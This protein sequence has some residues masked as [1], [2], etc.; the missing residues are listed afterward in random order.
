MTAPSIPRI[1]ARKPKVRSGCVTCKAR[2]VKC[3]EERPVCR[4]CQKSWLP[5]KYNPPETN[6]EKH[7]NCSHEHPVTSFQAD[8]SDKCDSRLLSRVR[9][10][11]FEEFDTLYLD[12]FRSAIVQNL[13]LNG[14][15][16]FWSR[17][18][19]RE[20]FRDECVRDCVLGIGALRRAM[21]DET[22]H[23]SSLEPSALWIVPKVATASLSTRYQRDAIRYYTESIS[24]FRSR[25]SR[26]GSSTPPRTILILSILFVM[27][28]AIQGNSESV[29]RIIHTTMLTLEDCA[30]GL[31]AEDQGSN[32]LDD[33]GV[34][35]ADYFLT[36][37][38]G[39]NSLLSP[40]YPSLL[41]GPVFQR[42]W[43]L[44]AKIPSWSDDLQQVE[45]AFE[46]YTT[47]S[48][49]WFLRICQANIFGHPT[50]PVK[51]QDEQ[52][53]IHLQAND[54]CEFISTK[55]GQETDPLRHRTWKM[56]LVEAKMFRIYSTYSR[57]AEERELLWDLQVDDC[58]EV[59][60]IIESILDELTSLTA[61][62]PLFED[63]LLPTLRCVAWKCRDYEIR[64]KALGLCKRLAGPWFENRA[65]L[66][67]LRIMI[68]LE[69]RDRDESGFIPLRSR[70]R[71][72]I[73]SF[74]DDRTEL[75]I[76]LMRL[77]TGA[78]KE[79]TI[80]QDGNIDDLV[81]K[82]AASSAKS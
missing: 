36:R 55:L 43:S 30:P 69:E 60:S 2:R 31:G 72:N 13:C 76:G 1:R 82:L 20:I 3:G 53:I 63:K 17:T 9:R 23:A 42:N 73:S 40:F 28:E 46:R 70:Y 47:S 22:Q 14:Y 21:V 44:A 15:T 6:Q 81:Q 5:C 34:R 45:L 50:D 24:K 67:G 32:S 37:F 79:F 57:D 19:L 33:E 61:L 80:R 26:E 78:R 27:F 39:Y 74:N 66:V 75:R 52:L 10:V 62:P 49:I 68:E 16:N 41:R 77:T 29:D 35:E 58:R 11:D 4:R 7:Q 54:W 56:M 65:V 18:I 59:L 38:S 71:W 48:L 25:L 12:L 64:M 8:A 51:N